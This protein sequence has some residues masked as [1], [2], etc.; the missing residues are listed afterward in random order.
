MS[1]LRTFI[2]LWSLSLSRQLR[3]PLKTIFFECTRIIKC[4]IYN[5]NVSDSQISRVRHL[6]FNFFSSISQWAWVSEWSGW[7]PIHYSN[8]GAYKNKNNERHSLWRYSQRPAR[9]DKREI[10]LNLTTWGENLV[11]PK[12]F[13][14]RIYDFY[15]V[16]K[17]AVKWK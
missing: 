3:I 8:W 5:A 15:Q 2:L 16:R 6:N 9:C 4:M 12:G 14:E 10:N 17:Y 13:W 11:A 1:H 7:N